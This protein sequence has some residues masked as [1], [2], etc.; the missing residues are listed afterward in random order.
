MS[1]VKLG[2]IGCGVIGNAHAKAAADSSLVDLVAVADIREESVREM[3]EKHN[4][5]TTYASGDELI[6][7]DSI[8]AVILAMPT[9]HRF[10]LAM[11]ALARKHVLT[12]KP[13]AMNSDQVR[14]MI[15]AKGD[16]VAACCSSRN[17]HTESAKVITDFIASGALGPLRL[18]HCRALMQAGPAPDTP[19]PPWRLNKKLN[20]GGILV[21][22]GCY[23]LDYLL[24]ITGWTAK[25]KTVLAQTWTIPPQLESH[26]APN[27]DAETYFA[28]L[29]RCEDGVMISFER[30]EYMPVHKE[31]SWQIIGTKGSLTMQMTPGKNK[32][33]I[34]DDTTTKDGLV[35]KILWEGDDVHNAGRGGLLDDFASA[36]LDKGEPATPLEKALVVQ[37]ITDAIYASADSGKAVEIE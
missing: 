7:D 36:I 15:E 35:Q 22:W 18:I 10:N 23:D 13:V 29:I 6:E 26:V 11:K 25:P 37:Q 14:K 16:L 2:I 20:G 3:A 9:C 19:R 24:G 34:H 33:V 32:K 27:S 21:N 8:E 12:E 5:P 17:R 28:A 31:Q 1:T 30:G 4:V